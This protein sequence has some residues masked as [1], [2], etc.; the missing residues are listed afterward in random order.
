M[1][2]STLSQN[3]KEAHVRPALLKVQNE[4]RAM[5]L[6]DLSAPL[7]TIDHAKLTDKL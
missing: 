7:D 5:T 4:I 3:F 6:L 1:G 2:T